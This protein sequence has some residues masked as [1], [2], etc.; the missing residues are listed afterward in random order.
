MLVKHPAHEWIYYRRMLAGFEVH[1]TI[2]RDGAIMTEAQAER[3]ILDH[4]AHRSPSPTHYGAGDA[5]AAVA[6]PVARMFGAKPGCLPCERRRI[7]MNRAV[8]AV[9][10]LR[11]R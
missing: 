6:K 9:P 3:F 4:S 1:C 5:F 2:C 10:F 7:E 11:R 8:P